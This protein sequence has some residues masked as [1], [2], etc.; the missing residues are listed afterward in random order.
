LVNSSEVEVLQTPRDVHLPESVA[1]ERARETVIV[2]VTD[3]KIL[4]QGRPVSPVAEALA[5]EGV[6]IP[7][8][9]DALRREAQGSVLRAAG[10][11]VELE[12]TIL[13][14]REIPFRLLKRVMASCTAADYHQLSLA[15]VQ[16]GSE[17]A[18]PTPL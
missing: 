17:P 2:T 9:T 10:G 15:V 1:E 5:G 7:A 12:V 16:K 8:V 18:A 6:A 11:D 13:G 3:E 4:V 14:D